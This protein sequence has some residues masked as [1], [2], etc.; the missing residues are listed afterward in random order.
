MQKI[1]ITDI[2]ALGGKKCMA[3]CKLKRHKVFRRLD[4]LYTRKKEF[5]FALLYFTGS[6]D[7]N[8]RMRNV[9]LSKGY[10]LSEYGMKYAEGNKK[11]DFVDHIFN[12]EEDIF[13]FLGIDYVEPAA[14]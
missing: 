7:F 12:S 14:R 11:G 5:P 3:V 9:A 8:V 13:K 10:S 4:L 1:Y 2:L 6:G